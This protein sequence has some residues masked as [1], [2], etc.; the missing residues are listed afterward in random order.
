MFTAPEDQ[1]MLPFESMA[2]DIG[3]IAVQVPVWLV[4][5]LVIDHVPT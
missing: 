1:V 4:T 5:V 2:I 3:D